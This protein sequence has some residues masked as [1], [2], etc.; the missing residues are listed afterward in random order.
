MLLHDLYLPADTTLHLA[1]AKATAGE[2]CRAATTLCGAR[3]R[4]ADP[5]R[6]WPDQGATAINA[7]RPAM[8]CQHQRCDRRP[9]VTP[10]TPTSPHP[11]SS[12]VL[13]K[14]N[15]SSIVEPII[16][17]VDG[18]GL[19]AISYGDLREGDL[20]SP[21]DG[22]TWYVTC[23]PLFGD[24]AVY[25]TTDRDPDTAP[26]IRVDVPE[27]VHVMTTRRRQSAWEQ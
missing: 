5:H 8:D 16:M 7:R 21:D 6:I 9:P 18:A 12:V 3:R 20:F 2:L 23:T 11:R 25:T 22:L 1:A 15:E 17:N 10:P 13:I 27:R 24:V 19:A 14:P 4:P 26:T